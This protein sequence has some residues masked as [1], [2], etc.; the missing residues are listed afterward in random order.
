M[1]FQSSTKYRNTAY[2]RAESPVYQNAVPC[3]S[4]RTLVLQSLTRTR[5]PKP[6]TRQASPPAVCSTRLV[7]TAIQDAP[8]DVRLKGPCTEAEKLALSVF[9]GVFEPPVYTNIYIY[10]NIHTYMRTYIYIYTHI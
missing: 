9:L 2:F 1:S 3:T 7:D 5:N 10:I 6:F 8:E 4:K